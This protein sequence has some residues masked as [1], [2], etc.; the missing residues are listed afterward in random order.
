MKQLI[1][2]NMNR[3]AEKYNKVLRPQLNKELGLGNIMAVPKVQ[4]VIINIGFL[5]CLVLF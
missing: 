3:L 4:K 5:L 2:N 1:N